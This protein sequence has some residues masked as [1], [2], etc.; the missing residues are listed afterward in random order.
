MARVK[1][2]G[3]ENMDAFP[4]EVEGDDDPSQIAKGGQERIQRALDSTKK[5]KSSGG[6]GGGMAGIGGMLGGLMG[7]GGGAGLTSSTSSASTTFSG[8]A[9]GGGSSL[10]DADNP[11]MSGNLNVGG[12]GS[13]GG[14]TSAYDQL[15]QPSAAPTKTA[16]FDSSQP[17]SMGSKYAAMGMSKGGGPFDSQSTGANPMSGSSSSASDYWTGQSQGSGTNLDVGGAYDT[18]RTMGAASINTTGFDPSAQPEQGNQDPADSTKSLAG[19]QS[20]ESGAGTHRYLDYSKYDALSAQQQTLTNERQN[21]GMFGRYGRATMHGADN[22]RQ[23]MQFLEL[24]KQNELKRAEFEAQYAHPQYRGAAYDSSG[25]ATAI[26]TDVNAPGGVR[27]V[28]L[29]DIGKTQ[30]V[31]GAGGM[32]YQYQNGRL[33]PVQQGYMTGRGFGATYDENGQM[34]ALQPQPQT[35]TVIDNAG[36]A[37]KYTGNVKFAPQPKAGAGG[38]AGGLTAAQALKS[39]DEESKRHTAGLN[40]GNLSKSEFDILEA[41]TNRKREAIR[42]G[43]GQ[44]PARGQQAGGKQPVGPP[45]SGNGPQGRGL[46]QH[47]SDGSDQFVGPAQ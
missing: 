41:Q 38:A 23:D 12:G 44:A 26:M 4:D 13:A 2:F 37:K 33:V 28:R 40:N 20:S 16:A 31:R 21:G 19:S 10:L 3:D 1:T 18:P 15:M 11:A 6:G 14:T 22:Y 47:Y 39:Y 45:R 8:D 25:N 42:Q 5:K 7:G 35:T 24:Q 46:Y 9:G 43:G 34:T 27:G 36:G 17:A 30:T 29:G 32:L